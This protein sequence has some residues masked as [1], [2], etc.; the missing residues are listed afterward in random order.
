[1]QWIIKKKK[2]IIKKEKK[3]LSKFWHPD[4]ECEGFL[5]QISTIMFD[6]KGESFIKIELITLKVIWKTVLK[7]RKFI[8]RSDVTYKSTSKRINLL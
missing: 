2:K 6:A 8:T 5:N 3:K 4:S 1:M 7:T